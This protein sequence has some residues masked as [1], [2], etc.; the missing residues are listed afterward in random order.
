MFIKQF[1]LTLFFYSVVLYW[2]NEN[3]INVFSYVLGKQELKRKE[4]GQQ[5]EKNKR[6]QTEVHKIYALNYR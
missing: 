4:K 1:F 3:K 5:K 6:K 2:E